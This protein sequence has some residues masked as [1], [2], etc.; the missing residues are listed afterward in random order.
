MKIKYA[1]P[2]EDDGK[3]ETKIRSDKMENSSEERKV[4][5]WNIGGYQGR[6]SGYD[7]YVSGERGVPLFSVE[8]VVL[9][10]QETVRELERAK[11]AIDNFDELLEALDEAMFCLN[12]CKT[13]ETMDE[14]HC[15]SV[16][17]NCLNIINK[18]KGK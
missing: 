9:S 17:Q 5:S 13:D 15:K 10:E 14:E 11:Q 4:R 1:C 7:L 2:C 8:P 16:A 12:H 6:E 3:C 18:A